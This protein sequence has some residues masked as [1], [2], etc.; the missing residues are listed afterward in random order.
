ML[1]NRLEKR[2]WR[3]RVHEKTART[4]DAAV[5]VMYEG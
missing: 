4:Y 3:I 5:N 2:A 1:L